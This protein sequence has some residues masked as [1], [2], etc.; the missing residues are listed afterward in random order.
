MSLHL[1]MHKQNGQIRLQSV[2]FY[3]NYQMRRKDCG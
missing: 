1:S 3:M 2:T